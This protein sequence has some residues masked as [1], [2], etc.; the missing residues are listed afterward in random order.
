MK[1]IGLDTKALRSDY[2]LD[3]RKNESMMVVSIGKNVHIDEENVERFNHILKEGFR[4]I[5]Q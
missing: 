2:H 4:N 3:S 1:E 5:A